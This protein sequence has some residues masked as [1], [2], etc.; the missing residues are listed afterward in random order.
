MNHL[1]IKTIVGLVVITC[2]LIAIKSPEPERLNPAYI[3][4]TSER[5]LT[6][7]QKDIPN[8]DNVKKA[9]I[10]SYDASRTYGAVWDI[11][12]TSEDAIQYCQLFKMMLKN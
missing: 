4:D 9:H 8:G 7:P 11:V 2:I 1:L 10:G 3:P 6:I 5:T 12:I